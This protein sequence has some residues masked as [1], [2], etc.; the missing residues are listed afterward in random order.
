MLLRDNGIAPSQAAV[1]LG[2]HGLG[3]LLGMAA[4]GR[5][6]E[7]FGTVPIL[8][9][10]LLV[11]AVCTG[12]LGYAASSLA[13]MSAVLFLIGMFVGT[14]ASGSIA[15]ATLTYPTAIR[16]SGIGWPWGWGGSA[17]C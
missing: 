6:M 13:A 2:V 5:L 11:G 4:A 9:P 12:L 10:A 14:G 8:V 7:R 16:S 17:R 15:L 1:A 3:A